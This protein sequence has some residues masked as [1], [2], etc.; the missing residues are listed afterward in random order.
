MITAICGLALD[1]APD[2]VATVGELAVS[3]NSRNTIPGRVDFTVDLR[4]PETAMLDEMDAAL[5]A[6]CAETADAFGLELAIVQVADTPPVAFDAACVDAV[7][8]TAGALGY[9]H[10]DIVSGAGHDA[11]H[12]AKVAPTGMIFIPCADGLSHNEAESA[13]VGDLEA[14]CNVL[15]HAVLDRAGVAS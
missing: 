2:A 1:R 7:R 6:L 12:L 5:R 14:G 8:T 9:G 15:L 4:H 10:R 3:P 11:F 13:T